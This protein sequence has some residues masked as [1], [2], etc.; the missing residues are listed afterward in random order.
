MMLGSPRFSTAHIL[1]GPVSL[2]RVSAPITKESTADQLP[3]LLVV[4]DIDETLVSAQFSEDESL[5][6]DF[7]VTCRSGWVPGWESYYIYKRPGCDAFIRWCAARFTV[8]VFT[9]G[10]KEY[11]TAVLEKLDPDMTLIPANNRFF[12][13]SLSMHSLSRFESKDLSKV[14]SDLSRVVLIDNCITSFMFQPDNGV[15]IAS[16]DHPGSSLCPH[17]PDVINNDDLHDFEPISVLLSELANATDVRPTLRQRFGT[18]ESLKKSYW[19]H[20]M[21]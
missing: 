15:P 17:T 7:K 4:L 2:E 14:T 3:R 9:A 12:R 20:Y 18:L 11:G 19:R 16:W 8:G 5:K 6:Y 10:T 13:C 1:T 21:D